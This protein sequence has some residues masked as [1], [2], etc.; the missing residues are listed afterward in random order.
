M[1]KLS[2]R[3]SE[4]ERFL[5]CA[6][7][8]RLPRSKEEETK[9]ATDGT[10]KH[11]LAVALL[12]AADGTVSVD[13]DI[14]SYVEYARG[15]TAESFHSYTTND[16]TLTGTCDA[17]N[18][19]GDVLDVVDLKTGFQEVSPYCAQLKGYAYLLLSGDLIQSGLKHLKLTIFQHG[20]ANSVMVPVEGFC[21]EFE[22]RL[23]EAIKYSPYIAGDH[24][25]YCP[26]KIYCLK[27]R[28]L[29]ECDGDVKLADDLLALVRYK[30][31][32]E[33]LTIDAKQHCL[34]HRKDAFRSYNRRTRVWV[35]ESIAPTE[36]KVMSVAKALR[37]GLA[38][39]SANN[40]KHV[41]TVLWKLKDV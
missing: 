21:E 25:T 30:S 37:L 23:L 7:S 28:S 3:C 39:T 15:Y 6:H 29:G 11:L 34:K 38:S 14:N 2:I 40:V 22:R 33:K 26:S 18:I 35:D 41:D 32:L 10:A 12:G 20:C 1:G 13:A 24:C 5:S 19:N 9:Y 16:Y 8:F 4:L 27:M 36:Q 17:Y 31:T